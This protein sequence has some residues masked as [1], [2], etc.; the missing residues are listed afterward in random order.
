MY[1]TT[2]LEIDDKTYDLYAL[3]LSVSGTY[4]PDKTADCSVCMRLVPTRVTED[5]VMESAPEA[6]VP[7]VMGSMVGAD[8]ATLA[9]FYSIQ[10]ALQTWVN[11]KGL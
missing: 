3:N 9:A 6:A 4:T 11:A 8:E 2:S 10:Q 1:L 7:V 5:G